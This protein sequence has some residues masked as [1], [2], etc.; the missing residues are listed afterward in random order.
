MD[1]GAVGDEEQVRAAATGGGPAGGRSARKNGA[2]GNPLV[3]LGSAVALAAYI[4][5]SV[6]VNSGRKA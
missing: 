1:V 2:I 6:G 5:A 4:R 3:G